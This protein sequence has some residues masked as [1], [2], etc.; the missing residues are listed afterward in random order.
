MGGKLKF[1]RFNGNKNEINSEFFNYINFND[2]GSENKIKTN[3]NNN[4]NSNFF[5]NEDEDD[6]DDVIDNDDYYDDN[7]MYSDSEDGE[8]NFIRFI[9]RIYNN[10]NYEIN[11]FHNLIERQKFL[12]NFENEIKKLKDEIYINCL[13]EIK[14]KNQ[15]CTICLID[16]KDVEKIKIFSCLQHIFHEECIIN[17]LKNKN[18]CPICRKQL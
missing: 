3:E 2:N 11:L 9:Q 1:V 5:I 13:P 6:E 7:E 18:N 10:N 16:F 8:E 4:N 12:R 14:L 15:K 17:W